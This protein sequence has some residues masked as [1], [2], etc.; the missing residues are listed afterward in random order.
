LYILQKYH[1]NIAQTIPFVKWS[2]SFGQMGLYIKNWA[3]HRRQY[4][5]ILEN[6]HPRSS[7]RPGL[8]RSSKGR[9]SSNIVLFFSIALVTLFPLFLSSLLHFQQRAPS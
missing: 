8:A 5:I 9:G 6:T 4:F 7:A 3:P 1:V 2:F